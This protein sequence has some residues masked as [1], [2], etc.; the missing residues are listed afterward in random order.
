MDITKQD[1]VDDAL[2]Y[3]EANLP[4]GEALW[5]LVNNAGICSLGFVEWL[6][7]EDFE[8]VHNLI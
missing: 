1:Q 8:K 5:G 7:M 2:Q 4:K 6:N 3:V